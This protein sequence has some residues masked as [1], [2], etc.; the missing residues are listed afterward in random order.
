LVGTNFKTLEK[1]AHWGME[2]G[3]LRVSDGR[4]CSECTE[5]DSV[6]KGSEFREREKKER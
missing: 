2:K 5:K 6:K 4:G 1:S 3:R